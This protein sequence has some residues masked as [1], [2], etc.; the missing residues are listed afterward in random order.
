M[1]LSCTG[2]P[3]ILPHLARL[4]ELGSCGAERAIAL[5]L[6]QTEGCSFV[7]AQMNQMVKLF[8]ELQEDCCSDLGVTCYSSSVLSV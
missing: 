6:G 2:H 3:V 1:L 5:S 4:A 8:T 7:F